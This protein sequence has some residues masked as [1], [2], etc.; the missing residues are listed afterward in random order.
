MV[1]RHRE[2]LLGFIDGQ[3]DVLFANEAEVR[4][5]VPDAA[6]S[7]PASRPSRGAVEIAAVTRGA[8]GSVVL[9]GGDTLP[10][11]AVPVEKV[12]DTTGAGD[13]YAAGFLF[14][15]ARRPAAGRLRRA[16]A[17]WPPPK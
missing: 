16:W 10:I 8:D 2:A 1:E 15:L 5:S 7:R 12:V 4:R 11:A 9:A 14:G 6:T 3:V 13:Q 17:R